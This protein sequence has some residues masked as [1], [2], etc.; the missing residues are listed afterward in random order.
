MIR[1]MER[2]ANNVLRVMKIK[3]PRDTGDLINSLKVET[4]LRAGRTIVRIISTDPQI[5]QIIEG[6]KPGYATPPHGPGTH[7]F[8]WGRRH[9]F[10]SPR[11]M[12]F[13]AR[14]IAVHG[15][16]PAGTKEGKQNWIKESVRE[17]AR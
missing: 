10:T 16:P 8:G 15:T 9:G 2:R 14:N 12:F 5:K 6:T 11:S 17:A 7:L 3:A 13:L 1:D 4:K